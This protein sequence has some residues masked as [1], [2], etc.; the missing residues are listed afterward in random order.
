MAQAAYSYAPHGN[1]HFHG[2]FGPSHPSLKLIYPHHNGIVFQRNLIILLFPEGHIFN[3]MAGMQLQADNG[4]G[5][6]DHDALAGLEVFQMHMRPISSL[7]S[8]S[9]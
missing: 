8:L 9:H 1:F 4:L 5:I 3:I 6:S 7:D 2:H